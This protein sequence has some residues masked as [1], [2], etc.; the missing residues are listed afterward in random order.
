VIAEPPFRLDKN[1]SC[2]LAAA[3]GFRYPSPPKGRMRTATGRTPGCT[4]AVTAVMMAKPTDSLL[5]S[6]GASGTARF[7]PAVRLPL[8]RIVG[9]KVAAGVL[10]G[11]VAG[12]F[13]A[14]AAPSFD[15]AAVSMGVLAVLAGAAMS[16]MILAGANRNG[17]QVFAWATLIMAGSM[18]R[19]MVSLAVALGL[20]F[21]ADPAK[22]PFFAAFLVGSLAALAVETIL[23]RQALLEIGRAQTSGP[24]STE[25]S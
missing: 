20:Y 1:S 17:R 5:P 3:E 4:S 9:A 25:P 23:T 2:P 19:L 18:V 12:L 22:A 21:A 8:G 24:S 6:Q 7:G 14:A 15:L 16:T 10:A 11:I 13:G